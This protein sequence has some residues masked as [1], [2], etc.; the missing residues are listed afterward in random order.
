MAEM[1]EEATSTN[2]R[3]R[4]FRYQHAEKSRLADV[5]TQGDVFHHPALGLGCGALRRESFGRAAQGSVASRKMTCPLGRG[6]FMGAVQGHQLALRG[7]PGRCPFQSRAKW[8]PRLTTLFC[9]PRCR[10]PAQA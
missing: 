5:E 4:D 3:A 6:R 9:S 2:Y 1:G 10:S 8:T 7:Q